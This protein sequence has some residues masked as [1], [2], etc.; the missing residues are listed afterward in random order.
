MKRNYESGEKLLQSTL[1]LES[2][3]AR[4]NGMDGA[5]IKYNDTVLVA[6]YYYQ[7]PGEPC[8][9]AA[10]YEYLCD[11]EQHN[12]DSIVWLRDASP[13]HFKDAGHAIEWALHYWA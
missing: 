6:G 1:N 10:V 11:D 13:V 7:G 9:F 3:E 5:V 2:L 4:F 8:Y 12:D